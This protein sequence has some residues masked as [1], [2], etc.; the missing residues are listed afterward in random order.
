MMIS[1]LATVAIRARF[2][3]SPAT[4]PPKFPIRS[5]SR[6]RLL[7][8]ESLSF[9]SWALAT[10]GSRSVRRTSRVPV[11]AEPAVLDSPDSATAGAGLISNRVSGLAMLACLRTLANSAETTSAGDCGAVEG[12]GVEVE[13][14]LA[15]TRESRGRGAVLA[16]SPDGG[17]DATAIGLPSWAV[18]STRAR[19][20][21]NASRIAF[22]TCSGS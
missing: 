4:V 7:A 12:R 1:Q 9:S 17:A 8:S 3:V 20:D 14:V 18:I 22:L 10:S 2:R 6:S 11:A 19:L 21:P 16:A 5:K 15:P 13:F